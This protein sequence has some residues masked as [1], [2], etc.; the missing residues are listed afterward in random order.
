MLQLVRGL[1]GVVLEGC[2]G[3]NVHLVSQE[4]QTYA[5]QKAEKKPADGTPWG[6]LGLPF[7][8]TS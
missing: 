2:R 4:V 8:G 5:P 6:Y 3:L 1:Q 7:R